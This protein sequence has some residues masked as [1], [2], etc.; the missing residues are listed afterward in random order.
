MM[1]Y[2]QTIPQGWDQ[3]PEFCASMVKNDLGWLDVSREYLEGKRQVVANSHFQIKEKHH[4]MEKAI[5][6]LH[7]RG[8]EE[9]PLSERGT[10]ASS[11]FFLMPK[12]SSTRSILDLK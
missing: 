4:A 1:P 10:G 12:R 8:I 11:V 6:H 2:L 5:K 9:I 3:A 7:I